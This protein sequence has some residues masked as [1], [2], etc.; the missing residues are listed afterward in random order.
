MESELLAILAT[1]SISLLSLLGLPLFSFRHFSF[2]MVSFAVGALLGDAIIHILPESLQRLDLVTNSWLVISGILLFFIIEKI[3][4]W[5]HCHNPDCLPDETNTSHHVVSL[6]VI[7][8][9]VH[10]FIDGMV[11]T[12]AFLID[13]RLG[14]VTSLAVVLHEIPQEIGDFGIYIHHGLTVSKALLVNFTSAAFALLGCFIVILFGSL[15]QISLYILPVTAGGFI[16]LAAS[17]LIPELHRH[18]APVSHS[19]IQV[20]GVLLG[21]GLML[22]LLPLE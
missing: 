10:N 6:S 17:D 1:V 12:S 16:Y 22:L 2:V 5:R 7:G 3:I 11:V 20:I 4:R 21:F 8:D 9:S 18:Q 13:L 19:L 15:T 14:L